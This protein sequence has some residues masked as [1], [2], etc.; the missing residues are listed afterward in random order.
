MLKKR[1]KAALIL[2]AIEDINAVRVLL[3]NMTNLASRAVSTYK[4]S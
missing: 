4:K 2:I 3:R 1:I